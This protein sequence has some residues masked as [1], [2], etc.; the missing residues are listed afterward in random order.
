MSD[1]RH[2]DPEF[3]KRQL[4]EIESD[5]RSRR[6]SL[7]VT[8]RSPEIE[9]ARSKPRRKTNGTPG[10]SEDAITVEAGK[11]HE[12]ADQGIA[13]LVG[14]EVPFYQRNQ[15]IVRIAP[16]PAKTTNGDTIIVPG[17]VPVEPAMMERELGR[18]APWQRFDMK[19]KKHVVIDPPHSVAMQILSMAGHWPFPPLSGI[20]QCP[21]LRR[22]GSLF[23]TAGYDAAT[24]LVLID[25]IS[26]PTIRTTRDDAVTALGLLRRLLVEFPFVDQ[27]SQAVALSMIITPVVRGAMDVVP[28]HLVTKPTPGTGASYLADCASMIATGERC[29]VKAAAPNYEETEKRLVGSALSGRPIIA[30]DNCREFVAGEFFCQIVERPLLE[31]RALGKSDMHRIPNTFTMFANGNNAQVAADLVRRTV[32]CGLDAN[33]EYPGTREFKGSPLAAIRQNRAQYIAAALTIPLAYMAAGHP[34]PIP[35]LHSFEGW[36][37][38][39][40]DPLIWLG[41]GDPV[42]TQKKLQATDPEKSELVG[43]FEAW[44]SELGVGPERRAHSSELIE[45]A[46]TRSNLKT[47]LLKIAPQRFGA[48]ID[49]TALGKRL[50]K[51]EGN[52][53]AKCKLIADRTNAARPKWYLDLQ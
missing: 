18:S 20:I 11:R 6:R 13:A 8:I 45:A 33:L 43:L 32:R 12:A 15:K 23:D 21:T 7:G 38:F 17:I 50:S 9:G 25:G 46:Q 49:P 40:R 30:L 35:P 4:D 31:L 28:M 41:C 10:L 48:D 34:N 42:A 37:G 29:P 27:E 1:N 3:C 22:D 36:S 47:E 52:I 51:Y 53:A 24:G 14:A 16:V 19:Q 26:L 5:S 2:L 39:V 44:K